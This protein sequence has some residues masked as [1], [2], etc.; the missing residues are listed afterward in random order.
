M[1]IINL[2]SS[3]LAST[4]RGWRGTRGARRSTQ[5]EQ[6]LQLYEYEGCPFCRMVR[7]ALTELDLDAL[8]Y[9]CPRGGTRFRPQ[10]EAVG[11]RRQFPLLVD[12]NT[13]TVLYESREIIAYLREHYGVGRSSE[14]GAPGTIG[15]ISASMAS[16]LRGFAG[17]RAGD[18]HANTTAPELPLELF[19]FESSPYSRLVRET[20]CELELAYVLRNTGKAVNADMGPPWVRQTFFADTP[21]EG[22]NR[23]RMVEEA[24]RVQVPY[25]IDANTGTRLFES[26]DINRY[27][28]STYARSSS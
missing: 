14:P 11:G 16:A 8:I 21:V 1:A 27:L 3:T 26:D 18:D 7:E 9:P 24:G 17:T 23:K 22:R 28:R 20:L 15:Q 4:A 19:S 10:A 5:P 12:D 25:L 6:M 13:D 2:I